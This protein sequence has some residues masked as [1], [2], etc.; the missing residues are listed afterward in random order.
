MK[1]N[2]LFQNKIR[3]TIADMKDTGAILGQYNWR[4]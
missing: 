1:S 2:V 4:S 3:D